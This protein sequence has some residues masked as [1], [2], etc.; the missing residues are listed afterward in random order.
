MKSNEIKKDYEVSILVLMDTLLQLIGIN[1]SVS[2]LLC[3]NPCFNGYT[4]S[5]KRML[6]I[7]GITSNFVSILV[8]MDTL[9][10]LSAALALQVFMKHVS[11][12][13]LMDTLLQQ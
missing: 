2:K 10:Q 1:I 7:F 12:L 8:L 11:I 4:T 6:L 13:V 3:F 9:L 5:T